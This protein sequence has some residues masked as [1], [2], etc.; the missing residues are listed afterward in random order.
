MSGRLR[1]F[2]EVLAAEDPAERKRTERGK[3]NSDLS[4]GEA[5]CSSLP[6][7]PDPFWPSFSRAQGVFREQ[8][9]GSMFEPPPLPASLRKNEGRPAHKRRPESSLLQIAMPITL[10]AAVLGIG[11]AIWVYWFGG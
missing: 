7:S 8:L 10:S 2:K 1:I 6:S 9:G 11:A 4:V 5:P 3:R